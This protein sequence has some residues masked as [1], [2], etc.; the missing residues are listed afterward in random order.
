MSDSTAFETGSHWLLPAEALGILFNTLVRLG[1]TVVGPTVRDGTIDYAPLESINDLPRGWTEVQDAASYRM[2]QR[3]DD[4]FF[5]FSNGPGSWKKFLRPEEELLWQANRSGDTFEIEHEVDTKSGALAFFGVRAC[6]LAAIVILDTVLRENTNYVARRNSLFTVAVNCS[7]AGGTCFCVSMKTGPQVA[8]SFDLA[9][10]EVVDGERHV[11]VIE[12]GSERGADVV[13]SLPVKKTNS[14]DLLKAEAII[15]GTAEQMERTLDTNGLAQA[16]AANLDH[17][18][19]DEVAERCLTCG[20]CTMV[21][22]T[23]YCT[24]VEDRTDLEGDHAERWRIWDSCFSLDFTY[25][26]G[27]SIRDS[28]R[29][30]YRQW[31]SHKLSTWVDQFGTCGCVGCGRCVTWCP[32]GIDITEEAK[33]ISSTDYK[34]GGH[35]RDP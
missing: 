15:R 29:S 34:E 25:A 18:H 24:T 32:V 30:R 26:A 8:H 2:K 23:C 31:L 27:G 19:W 3:E 11:F 5:G 10:T 17:P 22:P 16:I 12:V 33:A 7:S 1:Y 13:A 6:D 21:C 20:N 4:A 14:S 35:A 9:L 28:G